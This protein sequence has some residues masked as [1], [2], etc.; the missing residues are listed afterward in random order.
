M[1]ARISAT[2][3]QENKTLLVSWW[4]AVNPQ[5]A[6]AAG[7]TIQIGEAPVDLLFGSEIGQRLVR[8]AEVAE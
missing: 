6:A 2:A 4:T 1:M 7:A 5:L 3:E 8:I